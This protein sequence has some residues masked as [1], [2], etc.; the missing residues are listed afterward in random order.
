MTCMK[1]EG[2]GTGQRT[3]SLMGQLSSFLISTHF[4]KFTLFVQRL[5][6]SEKLFLSGNH[7][8]FLVLLIYRISGRPR[9]HCV[10]QASLDL[11]IFLHPLQCWENRYILT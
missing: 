1:M 11:V 6:L 7:L 3:P 5:F 2:W 4:I 8:L 9:T 10:P